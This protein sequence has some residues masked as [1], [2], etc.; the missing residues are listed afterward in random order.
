M[1]TADEIR[2]AL[3]AEQAAAERAAAALREAQA[4]LEAETQSSTEQIER[5]YGNG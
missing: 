2:D 3:L 1:A 5:M 4:L